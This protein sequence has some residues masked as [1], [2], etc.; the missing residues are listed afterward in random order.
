MGNKSTK[1]LRLYFWK[2][3]KPQEPKRRNYPFYFGSQ[4]L[5]IGFAKSGFTFLVPCDESLEKLE[6]QD[7]IKALCEK[8]NTR[9]ILSAGI[10]TGTRLYSLIYNKAFPSLESIFLQLPGK[11]IARVK[12]STMSLLGSRAC[13]FDLRWKQRAIVE[14][15]IALRKKDGGQNTVLNALISARFEPNH[16]TRFSLVYPAIERFGKMV[17]ESPQNGS[18]SALPALV[19]L[20]SQY[21]KGDGTNPT[22]SEKDAYPTKKSVAALARKT[23]SY[24]GETQRDAD[25][26]RA[27]IQDADNINADQHLLGL[28]E[29]HR[30]KKNGFT[31]SPMKLLLFFAPHRFR[32]DRFH[33]NEPSNLYLATIDDWS[34][35]GAGIYA[36]FLL[37]EL[38]RQ[39]LDYLEGKP[40]IAEEE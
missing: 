28:I 23:F 27:W 24:V 32:C 6:P 5:S 11:E 17:G 33:A 34:Y 37:G 9:D 36:D 12:F 20:L 1:T 40:M 2:G 14:K 18:R 7:L 39:Y 19:I 8:K 30:K 38:E 21:L 25:A 4:L 22:A 26:F 31:C 15:I 3:S 10:Q 35:T 16:Y 29:E 13:R